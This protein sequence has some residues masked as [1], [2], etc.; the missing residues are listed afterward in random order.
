MANK[1]FTTTLGI[2]LLFLAS[3]CLELGFSLVVRN[4]MDSKPESGQEA[5]RNLL[6]QMFPLT[7]GIA[8]GAATL[9][10]FAFTLLGLMS[11]M[12]SWL[13]AGGYLI[14]LCG[15]FTLC[16]GVYLWIMTLR[17]K[18]GFFPTYLEL[19]P[20]V[21]SLVQQSF[22]CC[23]YY[24]AT[25]PAFVTDPTCPSP[26][27]A[28]LLRG[29]GTAISSFSNTFIDNI[30]TALFGIV[31]LDAILILSIAC[32]LKERKERERYRHI[33]EKSGFRQF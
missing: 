5:V 21:Q 3:G 11:P 7:A 12:R 10:T 32:L 29:C 30:F 33:D 25:T 1:V 14:T 17:L 26:A 31:G 28:A 15:L 22:Q 8:N 23:G 2:S 13:K 16:L 27:A 20:G 24:N 4:M 9:A 6:Y 19:E 18:D